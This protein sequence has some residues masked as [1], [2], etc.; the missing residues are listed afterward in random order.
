[1][2]EARAGTSAE[3]L[4]Q[5]SDNAM[6]AAKESGRNRVCSCRDGQ[7]SMGGMVITR[8]ND[9]AFESQT[10]SELT[11]KLES[12]AKSGLLSSDVEML[13][14]FLKT[15]LARESDTAEHCLLVNK[16]AM[17][18]G[19]KI[20]LSDKELLQLNWGSLLHDIGKLSLNDSV[21]LKESALTNS[22]YSTIKNHPAIGHELLKN[23]SY[24][25]AGKQIILFH[26]EKWDGTGYPHQLAEETIP[27]LVRICSVADS[28]AAMG[29]DR[30]YRKALPAA[31]ILQQLRLNSGTQFDPQLVA[32]FISMADELFNDPDL[33][34]NS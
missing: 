29:V 13:T 11:A 17:I 8:M 7:F 1:M 26:H 14:A 15:L 21:L 30:P 28:V 32:V 22:E 3:Q 12:D 5:D 23:N 25:G 18:M 2:A 10:I 34:R 31:E 24:I 9:I 4:I 20:G 6:Y 16:I 27:L 33:F 19:R